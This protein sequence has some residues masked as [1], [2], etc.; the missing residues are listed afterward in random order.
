MKRVIST[1]VDGATNTCDIPAAPAV[2]EIVEP[3]IV[4]LPKR[5]KTEEENKS[6]AHHRT[7]LGI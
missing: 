5:V 1:K 6:N 4:H 7:K 3:S 2:S